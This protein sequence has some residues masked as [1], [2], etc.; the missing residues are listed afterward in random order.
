MDGRETPPET[1]Q[2]LSPS[3][4]SIC[5]ACGDVKTKYAKPV[6][7]INHL[8]VCPLEQSKKTKACLQ[9]E[10]FFGIFIVFQRDLQIVCKNYYRSICN[11]L[12]EKETKLEN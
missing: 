8:W 11:A 4:Y 5:V 3:G 9:L 2:Y 12:K 6:D 7:M 1:I 10:H